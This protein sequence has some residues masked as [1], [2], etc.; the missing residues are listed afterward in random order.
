MKSRTRTPTI[1]PLPTCSVERWYFVY[2]YKKNRNDGMP[3]AEAK[4][5]ACRFARFSGLYCRGM[6]FEN[7]R[8]CPCELCK[9][10]TA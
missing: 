4:N 5:D 7:S 8:Q 9:R 1:E 2:A 3:P 6:G 10:A